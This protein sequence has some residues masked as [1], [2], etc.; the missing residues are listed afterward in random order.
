MRDLHNLELFDNT[1]FERFDN[2]D[3]ELFDT[4]VIEQLIQYMCTK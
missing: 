4:T 3:F 1:D 2:T